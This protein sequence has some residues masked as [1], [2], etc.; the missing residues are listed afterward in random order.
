VGFDVVGASLGLSVDGL[1]VVGD[2]PG[3]A[4]GFDVVGASLGLSVDGWDVVGDLLLHF[5]RI[6][7]CPAKS[8]LSISSV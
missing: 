1:D 5:L 2:L 6:N 8:T 4:V 3:L 7:V